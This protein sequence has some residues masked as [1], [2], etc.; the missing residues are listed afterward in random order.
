VKK[1]AQ[2]KH[3]VLVLF[4]LQVTPALSGAAAEMLRLEANA[5][6]MGSTY[7]IV[8]YDEDRNKMESAAADG[9]YSIC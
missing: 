3:F 6:A 8:L 2:F 9:S 7:S 1:R 4:L 5:D